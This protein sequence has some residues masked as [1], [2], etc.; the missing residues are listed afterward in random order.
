MDDS[1]EMW[2]FFYILSS[3]KFGNF[4]HKGNCCEQAGNLYADTPAKFSVNN[5]FNVH[6]FFIH[7]F[8]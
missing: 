2:G 5:F 3:I 1:P 6:K 8:F 4:G 7:F